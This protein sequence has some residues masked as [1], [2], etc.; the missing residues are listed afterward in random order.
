MLIAKISCPV[1]GAVVENGAMTTGEP[2]VCPACGIAFA[3]P[4]IQSALTSPI[5]S[6]PSRVEAKRR[7]SRDRSKKSNAGLIWLVS[8]LS[9]C[10]ILLSIAA[11]AG[12]VYYFG[13]L[14]GPPKGG[15]SAGSEEKESQ[16]GQ[17]DPPFDTWI[18]ELAKAKERAVQEHKDLLVLFNSSDSS[19]LGLAMAE[20][21]FAKKAFRETI[22]P[23][24]IPVYL[25]FPQKPSN[26]GKV[27]DSKQNEDLKRDFQVQQFP[28]MFLTDA[29]GQPF[30][31]V[32]FTNDSAEQFAARLVA[33]KKHHVQRDDLFKKAD[34][35]EGADKL[36]AGARALSFLVEHGLA[37]HYK[38]QVQD[39]GAGVGQQDPKNEQ[40][41]AEVFFEADWFFE[42]SP[43]VATSSSD[44]V[45]LANRLDEWKK[46]HAFKDRNR[47]AKLHNSAGRLAAQAGERNVAMKYALDG[48]AY[49]P[50]NSRLYQDLFTLAGEMGL[51]CGSGFVVAPGGYVLTNAH[52][53]AGGGKISVR[54]NND[55]QTIP[56]KVLAEDGEHDIALLK[57]DNRPGATLT[58]APLDSRRILERGED[59]A[60]LGFPL[61]DLFG[62]G[63]KLTTGRVSATPESGTNNMLLLENKINPGNSGGPLCD[64]HG[65]VVGMIS[66]KTNNRGNTDSYGLALTGSDLEKFLTRHLK[67][68][69]VATPETKTLTWPEVNRKISPSVLMIFKTPG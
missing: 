45:R 58:P 35:S 52:V 37:L 1:C 6:E 23:H 15:D 44:L 8:G 21:I 40:G 32:P 48:M 13:F 65:N 68:Y 9:A 47:A 33:M 26:L 66:A 67:D 12:L 64:T 4:M 39:W 41:L 7:L 3:L 61:G 53:V 31:H 36:K 18:Q 42:M 28:M 57:V 60:A 17:A 22:E 69:K 19:P 43:F 14:K 55:P 11:S 46:D 38:K 5:P 29:E 20:N 24:Y 25:D 10:L 34:Q 51:T 27:A 49:R 16:T 62:T 54:V 30:A 59:V 50:D 63:I 56:A 2:L